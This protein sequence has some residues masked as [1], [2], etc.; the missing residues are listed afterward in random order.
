MTMQK[1]YSEPD[2]ILPGPDPGHPGLEPG[3]TSGDS[4]RYRH[5]ILNR[6]HLNKP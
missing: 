3:S 2:A 4:W 6:V 5:A 1:R